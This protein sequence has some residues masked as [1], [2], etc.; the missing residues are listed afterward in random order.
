MAR[1]TTGSTADRRGEDGATLTLKWGDG[2]YEKEAWWDFTVDPTG[3]VAPPATG[4][5]QLPNI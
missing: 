4:G 1:F 5:D 3:F 2:G